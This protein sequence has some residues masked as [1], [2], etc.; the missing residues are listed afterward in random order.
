MAAGA[1]F[2]PLFVEPLFAR[3][4]VGPSGG[5]FD[6][7]Q[8]GLEVLKQEPRRNWVSCGVLK[9][10][11]GVSI[12][13]LAE[14]P[15]EGLPNQCAVRSLVVLRERQGQVVAGAVVERALV[16]RGRADRAK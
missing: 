1:V 8:A 12:E 6:L 3:V 13:R 5:G 4:T 14:V 7:G 11:G 9:V 2:L 16:T 15:A 10:L